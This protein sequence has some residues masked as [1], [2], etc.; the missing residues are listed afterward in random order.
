MPLFPRRVEVSVG[1][2]SESLVFG[3]LKC[4]WHV[5]RN[6]DSRQPSGRISLYNLQ[7][8]SESRVETRYTDIRLSA[9]Y[10]DRF[11]LLVSG[12]IRENGVHRERQGLDRI[13][14]VEIGGMVAAAGD[15]S[16]GRNAIV[17]VSYTDAVPLETI[18]QHLASRMG[19]AVGSTAHVA[20]LGVEVVSYASGVGPAR[21]HLD[22]LLEPYDLAWYE[23][24]GV[25][26]F[27]KAGVAGIEKRSVL[28]V[29]EATGMIGTPGILEAGL[30]LKTLIDHRVE[31]DGLVRVQSAFHAGAVGGLWKVIRIL[32]YGDSR[33]GEAGTEFDVR[34]AA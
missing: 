12:Q 24:N 1:N 27:R 14:H 13:T 8:D 31:L 15:P 4:N 30:R 17:D 10:P 18:V 5:E 9:G 34:A 11:G 7:S 32:H 16:R 28:Q 6:T 22:R 25:I 23:D 2:S 33:E 20:S 3:G 29:S 21:A 19:L 26:R